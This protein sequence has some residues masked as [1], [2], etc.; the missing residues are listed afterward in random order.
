[1]SWPI[2]SSAADRSASV[3]AP[4]RR[5]SSNNCCSACPYRGE[6]TDYRLQATGSPP[7]PRLSIACEAGVKSPV[8][9]SLQ[10][11]ASK[12]PVTG[13]SGPLDLRQALAAALRQRQQGVEL[14][15]AEGA[16][17][18]GPLDFDEFPR[19]VHD[20]V[21]VDFGPAVFGVVEVEQQLACHPAQADR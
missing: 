18:G 20:D 10:P 3:S 6:A 13:K 21:G 4:G 5:R 17:L 12:R 19:A 16:S 2:A 11:V 7:A 14:S 9:R 15:A 1:M 8:A